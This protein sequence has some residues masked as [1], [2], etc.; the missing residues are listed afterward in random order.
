MRQYNKSG[1]F[2]QHRDCKIDKFGVKNYILFDSFTMETAMK[3]SFTL[4]VICILICAVLCACGAK[5]PAAPA[6]SP[7]PA[8]TVE[9]TP[10]P[11]PTPTPEPVDITLP[12][13]R[14]CSIK[15]TTDLD[16]SS[17]SPSLAESTAEALKKLP[18]LR[19]VNLGAEGGS[20][21]FS[22]VGV[23]QRACPEVDFEY[24]F[25]L[26]D[27]PF[28]TLDEQMDLNHITMNDQGEAVKAVLP[29]MTRCR[30][31]D[32]DFCNVDSEHMAAIR[33]AYPEMEV[34]WRIWFGLDCSVR[35]NVE[36]I[37]ASNFG[38][39]L[40]GDNTKEL[41]Y[42]TKVK[43]LDIGHQWVNDVS[44]LQYMPDLEIAVLFQNTWTDL[45]PIEAC[46]KLRYLEILCTDNCTDISPLAKL[47]NL[48]FLNMSDLY[49]VEDF[50]A[51]FELTKLKR[52]FIANTQISRETLEALQ[53]ALPDTE[54]STINQA[55]DNPGGWKYQL[56]GE[57]QEY[58]A[59]VADAFGYEHYESS[60][61][62]NDPLY[63]KHS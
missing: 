29:Y 25:T 41:K 14:I 55:L 12:D 8:P 15:E 50:S 21:S 1:G 46:T 42:C 35:T 37:L 11:T 32:M 7:T 45:S 63:H 56:S 20:L 28:T 5:L 62:S 10:V 22:E 4:P 19:H 47:K 61:I 34:V 43:Y 30:F 13:G 9:P 24:A 54:I 23:F 33:D 60:A 2:I 27:L 16:L 38:H 48:E 6:P 44:F 36:K 3:K 31:L 40:S 52:L 49:K 39:G 57:R 53:A 58:W 59:E 26:F 17:L 18:N 51:L